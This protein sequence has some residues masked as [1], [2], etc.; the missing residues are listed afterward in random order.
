[1]QVQENPSVQC[2]GLEESLTFSGLLLKTPTLIFLVL[3]KP[4]A[5]I[6]KQQHPSFNAKQDLVETTSPATEEETLTTSSS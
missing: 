1:M 3:S 6:P 4:E 2:L 5:M